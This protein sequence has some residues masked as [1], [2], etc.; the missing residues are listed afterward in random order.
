MAD[1][2]ISSDIAERLRQIAQSKHRTVEDVAE[3]VLTRYLQDE[4]PSA[5][6]Q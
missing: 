4:A 5:A 1:I 6:D 2:T 3:E